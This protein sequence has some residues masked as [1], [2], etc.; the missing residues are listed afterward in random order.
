[1]FVRPAFLGVPYADCHSSARRLSNRASAPSTA[2]SA[3]TVKGLTRYL[4]GLP[5]LYCC[6][7]RA[8]Q[9]REKRTERKV[10]VKIAARYGDLNNI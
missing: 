9:A 7:C 4:A 10:R 3:S 1:M 6:Q 8:R 2:S 5:L